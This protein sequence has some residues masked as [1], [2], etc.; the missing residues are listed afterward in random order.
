MEAMDTKKILPISEK[1]SLCNFPGCEKRESEECKFIRGLC[2]A[3]NTAVNRRI[4]ETV[5]DGYDR[6]EVEEDLMKQGILLP[7]GQG[8][9]TDLGKVAQKSVVDAIFRKFPAKNKK[10]T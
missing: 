8:A 10:K 4:R 7:S 2:P 3:H 1:S 9:R 5:A 6:K